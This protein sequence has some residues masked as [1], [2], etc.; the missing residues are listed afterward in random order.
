MEE[1]PLAELP[2]AQTE[3]ADA[4]SNRQRI[5]TAA[6]ALFDERGAENVSMQDVAKAACV[7]MGTMYRRFG[8]RVGLTQALLSESHRRFQEEMVR[9]RPPLGP[10]A[11]ARERLHAFGRGYLAIL[12]DHAPTLVAAGGHPL[13][14]G[15]E[16]SYR[17]HLGI[18]LR[19]SGAEIADV[20]YAIVSLMAVFDPRVH[21]HLRRE[22]DWS[23]ERTQDGWC[24]LADSWLG[25]VPGDVSPAPRAGAGEGA[26]PVPRAAAPDR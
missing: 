9:G 21:L 8:D 13:L 25:V 1:L 12:D 14:A 18:L 15:P 2:T 16:D 19:E 4:A 5:L 23:L 10:G 22:R 3:R 7:G 24:A 20:D 17:M 26:P 6:S 11:P